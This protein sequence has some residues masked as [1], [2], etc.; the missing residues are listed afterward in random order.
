MI[1]QEKIPFHKP[2]LLSNE[3]IDHINKETKN[4][5]KSGQLSK[6]GKWSQELERKIR[7]R[8]N[9]KY[10]LTTNNCTTG[11]LICLQFIEKM[12]YI[13]VPM[14]EWWSV[15]YILDSIQKRVSWI[16]IDLETWL[17]NDS[18]FSNSLYINTFGNIGKSK[19]EKA[20][21]DSSHCLGAKIKHI[22]LAHVFSLAPTKLVT[23]CEGGIII[24]NNDNFY[25][26]AIEYRDKISRMSEIHA[27]IG[28]VYLNHLDEILKWKKK[29]RKYYEKN[30][31]GQFQKILDNS[32]HNTIGFLNLEKL[33]MPEC[34]EIK[35]YYEPIFNYY[36]VIKNNTNYVYDNIICLPSYYNCPYKEIVEKIKEENDL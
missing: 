25:E 24:T 22:G 2:Y 30:I 23:S 20:I 21:Y 15:K 35:Q 18:K 1:N 6:N 29:V 28:N 9:V 4:I 33:K 11:L 34:V 7:K 31:L 16:D 14:F 3:E 19:R 27:L 36:N 12:Y 10:A 26:F 8:Y 13:Q 5:I 17:P 32:T